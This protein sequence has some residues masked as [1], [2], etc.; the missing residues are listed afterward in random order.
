MYFRIYT[1]ACNACPPSFPWL[2]DG[3]SGQV[4]AILASGQEVG[5]EVKKETKPVKVGGLELANLSL[6]EKSS[7]SG[8]G[9][10]G[11]DGGV[12]TTGGGSTMAGPTTST[13]AASLF[14]SSQVPHHAALGQG[15]RGGASFTDTLFGQPQLLGQP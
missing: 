3:K 10:L 13:G 12:L 1:T 9:G 7:G 8:S 14:S 2:Y 4:I 11:S 5:V 15:A 6:T